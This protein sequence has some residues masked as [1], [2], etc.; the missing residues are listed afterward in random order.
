[1]SLHLFAG[2][3]ETEKVL[4][5]VNAGNLRQFAD[6]AFI[7]ELLCWVRFDKREALASLDGLYSSC[8]GNPRV[9]RW[10][11][12]QVPRHLTPQGQAD[13]DAK[14]LRSSAGLVAIASDRENKASWVRTGQV[15]QRLALRM[16]SMGVKSAI[17]NQP[18]EVPQVRRQFQ[19]AL[20]FGAALPQ[21]LVRFG[22]AEAMPTSLP[23]S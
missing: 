22:F 6:Q 13:S 19:S 14:K 18:N 4:E 20:G 10:L 7:A 16:T 1:M 17:L 5:F 11:G 8:T 15:Y 2:P 3:T 21:L 12:E 9:P 23:F